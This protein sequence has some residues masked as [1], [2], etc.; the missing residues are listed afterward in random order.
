MSRKRLSG[1]IVS[2][3]MAKTVVV[4]VEQKRRH[5]LYEKVLPRIRKYKAHTEETLP[6]GVAVV[7]EQAR[8]LS[9]EKRWRVVEVL[10]AGNKKGEK[11]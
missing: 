3:K 9:R 10:A 7:I 11:N 2:N 1:K 8:P 6:L 4:A 5:P